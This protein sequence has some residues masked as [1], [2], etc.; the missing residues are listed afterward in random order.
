[1][2]V[3]VCCCLLLFVVV[4]CCLLLFVVICCCFFVVGGVCVTG[5]RGPRCQ[6]GGGEM[7]AVPKGYLRIQWLVN[8][9]HHFSY[10]KYHVSH[11][12]VTHHLNN[13]I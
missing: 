5:Q 13:G 9:D 11:V 4:C 10:E 12:V 8:V 1:L 6:M 2:F 3:V 7:S